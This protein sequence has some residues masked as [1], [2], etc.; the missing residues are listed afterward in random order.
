MS[1]PLTPLDRELAGLISLLRRARQAAVER[2]H[3]DGGER[4]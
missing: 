2:A 3:R 4:R 1:E